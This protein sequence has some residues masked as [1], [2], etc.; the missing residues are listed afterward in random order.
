[1]LRLQKTSEKTIVYAGTLTGDA[2]LHESFAQVAGIHG[3]RAANVF[4]LGGLSEVVLSA[5]D[6]KKGER[7]EPLTLTGAF[8]IV[9]GHGLIS[10]LDDN[11]HV[12]LHLSLSSRTGDDVKLLG[13]HVVSA[14]AFAVEFTM[15]S[16]PGAGLARATDAGTGLQLLDL[17]PV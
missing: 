3:V 6:F 11:P 13:G 12:H 4:M 2:D 8:E 7:L 14:K 5:Y 1:M 15:L 17:P 16:Y 10:T 9:G